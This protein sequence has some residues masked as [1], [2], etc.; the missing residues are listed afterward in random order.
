[1]RDISAVGGRT[2]ELFL[3]ALVG[4][5]NDGT[6]SPVDDTERPVLHI[7]L[8]IRLL[9]P[10]TD[11]TFGVEDRVLRVGVVGVLGGVSDTRG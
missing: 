6:T 2:Y 7:L 1:M 3:L 8:D 11:E 10:A 4:D 9:S 5:L